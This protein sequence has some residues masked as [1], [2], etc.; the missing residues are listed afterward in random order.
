MERANYGMDSSKMVL[1]FALLAIVGLLISISTFFTIGWEGIQGKVLIIVGLIQAVTFSIP[2]GWMIYSSLYGKMIVAER[3]IDYDLKLQGTER[4][5]DC[6]CG[7]GLYMIEIAKRL[8]TGLCT[9]VDQ[10]D[11]NTIH[12]MKN[13]QREGV[14][15]RCHFVESHLETLPF[16]D[17]SFDVVISGLTLQR[18]AHLVD[19]VNLINEMIRVCRPGGKI[20]LLDLASASDNV[21]W[22]QEWNVEQIERV[23]PSFRMF[24]PVYV[25]KGMKAFS[26]NGEGLES[27]ID[28]SDG[29]QPLDEVAAEIVN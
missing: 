16:E 18:Y 27:Q 3:V 23:G 6:G 26:E 14:F 12:L 8:T 10:L 22:M 15:E 4:V 24:P 5:L 13:I 11:K 2:F 21:T 25:M 29:Y 1:L 19:R 9:G 7:N 17:E 28:E 20:V